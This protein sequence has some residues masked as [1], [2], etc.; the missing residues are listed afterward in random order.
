MILPLTSVA[1]DGYRSICRIRLPVGHLTVL[2]GRNGVGKTNLY[3]ALELLAAAARGGLS[4]EIPE[5]GGIESVLWADH[6][7]V[8]LVATAC[9]ASSP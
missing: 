5:E 2:A 4:R 7:E 3:R 8:D 9:P 1:V 6:A